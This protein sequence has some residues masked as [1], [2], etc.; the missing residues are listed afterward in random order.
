MTASHAQAIGNCGKGLQTYIEKMMS[1]HYSSGVKSHFSNEQTDRGN[2]YEPIARSI[3][4]LEQGVEVQQVGFIEFSPFIGAS[5]D[6]LVGEDGGL[7]IKSIQDEDHFKHQLRGIKEVESKHIWQVQMNLLVT[8]RQ[9]WDLMIYNPNYKKSS[10]IYRIYPDP[11]VFAKLEAGFA[12]G[13]AMINDI[14]NK[15]ENAS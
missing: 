12:L 5:P 3:Y 6:G 10:C 2:E 14:K 1:E 8:G 4:E 11:D 15:I 7:E 13:E 9:W